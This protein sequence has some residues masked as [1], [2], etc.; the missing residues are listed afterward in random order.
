VKTHRDHFVVG[1]TKE[2][3]IQRMKTFTSNLPDELVAQTLTLKDTESWK[4]SIARE[5][6]KKKDWERQIYPYA[7]RPF[8][9]RWI[10][11]EPSLVDRDRAEV[12]KHILINGEKNVGLATT[13]MLANPPFVHAFISN[14]LPDI[15][16][17]STKT[18]ETSYFFPLYL[19]PDN[20][21]KQLLG[22]G[23]D[24][25]QRIPNF[26]DRFLQ[27]VK[28]SLGAESTPE[29]IFYYIYAILYSSS[30]RKRYEE[31]LK[32]DFP[33]I[34]FVDDYDE[35]KRLSDLGKE[36]VELHLM[37]KRLPT[38]V[39]FDTPGSNIAETVKYENGKVWINKEQCF[40]GV[41]ENVW[42]FYIG[43]YQILD[44]WLKSRKDR[45]LTTEEI[46]QLRLIAEI[47]R[48]TMRI[49]KEIDNLKIT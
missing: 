47:I 49:M 18:K 40:D 15:C 19:Y 45:E 12:M 1:F 43:G 46:E 23:E 26:T 4:L 9:V 2:E 33:R 48:E 35:F 14:S 36:L 13:R 30:Y 38:E 29:E 44:K 37:K 20:L 8:D 34:P 42:N 10:C 39:K 7:Y 17:V 6:I 21:Q 25:Q 41:P 28:E 5:E 27:A 24:K 32:I 22:Q 16:L 11:Y 3:I 31:F